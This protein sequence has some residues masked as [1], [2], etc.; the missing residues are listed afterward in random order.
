MKYLLEFENGKVF[1]KAG[2]IRSDI[3]LSYHKVTNWRINPNLD[4]VTNDAGER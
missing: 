3:G 1:N 4:F 2:E